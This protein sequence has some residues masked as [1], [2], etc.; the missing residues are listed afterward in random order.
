[1]IPLLITGAVSLASTALD[2]WQ[3]AGEA[4]I[5]A[6]QQQQPQVKFDDLLSKAGFATASQFV[7]GTQPAMNQD[8]T[9]G[10]T[11]SLLQAPELQTALARGGWPQDSCVRINANGDISMSSPGGASQNF[12]V[13]PQTRA[14]ALQVRQALGALNQSGLT[15]QTDT[16]F[17]NAAPGMAPRIVFQVA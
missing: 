10:L 15:L 6:S 2:A 11:R 1:M 7:Y 16:G 5:A 4:K 14:L 9:R 3:K 13:G 8:A 12:T 17:T